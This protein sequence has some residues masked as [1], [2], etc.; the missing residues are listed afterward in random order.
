M[1]QLETTLKTINK[2]I[3]LILIFFAVGMVVVAS[4]LFYLQIY[5]NNTL[6]DLSIKNCT[7]VKSI[8][9]PRGNIIDC[10]GNLLATNRPLI[11]IYWQGSGNKKLTP[12]QEHDI[13]ELC[14]ILQI[15]TTEL[16]ATIKDAEKFSKQQ[17]LAS[18]IQFEE[19]SKI[20]ELFADN[21]NI[22]IAS[23]F[24]RFYP[25]K[26]LACH[27][28]GYLSQ[29]S[30]EYIGKMGLE[31]IFENLLK[32][33][34]GKLVS[35]INSTGKKISQEEIIKAVSGQTIET[36]IDLQ[37]QQMAE[38]AFPADYTG[39]VI[40][41]NPCNGD[42]KALVSRPN[43]DPNIFLRS[44][45][46][47][48]WQILQ[49][50][51]PFI[52]R[53]CNA[54]YPPASIFKLVSITTGLE[55]KLLDENSTIY[56]CGHTLFAGRKYHCAHKEGHGNLSLRDAFAKSCNI[57]FFELGKKLKIDTIAGYAKKFGLGQKTGII[58]SEKTGLI[59]TNS[60]KLKKFGERWWP[61]ETLSAVIGQSYMLVTPIQLARML[62]SVFTG[63]LVKPRILTCEDIEKEPININ[64]NTLQLV[65]QV[66]KKVVKD[67]TGVRVNAADIEVYGKT[68]TAQ[69][70]D[71]EK[72][73]QGKAFLEHAW[74]VSYFKY[75]NTEPL[76]MVIMIENAGGSSLAVT[77]AKNIIL[78][79]RKMMREQEAKAST[80]P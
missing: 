51:R 36:C 26:S 2:K 40:I 45:S 41:M 1:S 50:E 67:G 66:L 62:S 42:V 59:P 14:T 68:G 43:F 23:S 74:F 49:T 48:E 56:C 76:T 72:R 13:Q 63:Y 9:S 25:Y 39:S 19:L 32:G 73:N 35:T 64:A 80:L 57:L 46:Y 16:Y 52:N 58:L 29:E 70:S 33:Q 15:T 61:G 21:L 24:K 4:R 11:D 53:A 27:V 10:H 31:Q 18:D 20:A 65:Q 60:W 30:V 54:A 7:R 34:Q 5:Q 79:Y 77:A 38:S 75:K 78:N 55:E 12:K 8:I 37:L 22:K 6:L 47:E 28:L 17:L 71:L 44:I 3:Y 69:T